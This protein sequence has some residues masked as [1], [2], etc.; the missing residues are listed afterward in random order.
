MLK[1]LTNIHS[2]VKWCVIWKERWNF[3]RKMK[4]IKGDLHIMVYSRV[5]I[6]IYCLLQNKNYVL[7]DNILNVE[8]K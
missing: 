8:R 4:R 6:L 3:F 5:G 1:K 2:I 7:H